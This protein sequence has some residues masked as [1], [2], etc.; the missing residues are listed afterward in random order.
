MSHH[1]HLDIAVPAAYQGLLAAGNAAETAAKQV[2]L[3]PQLIELVR[4]RCS[5]LNGC[6]FCLRMHTRDAVR[7]GETAERLAVLATWRDTRYFTAQE[8]AALAIAEETTLI[9][10]APGDRRDSYESNP[11][12]SEEQV[13]AVRWVAIMINSF[14]RVAILSS[15]D[16]SPTSP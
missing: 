13:A 2:G 4:I 10:P 5:Q 1:T 16:V 6:A 7:H 9:R 8:R 14:N 12:L 3:E 11:T 15:Y